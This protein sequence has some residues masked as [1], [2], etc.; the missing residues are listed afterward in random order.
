MVFEQYSMD[1]D[2]RDRLANEREHYLDKIKIMDSSD[3]DGGENNRISRRQ[4]HKGRG[5]GMKE[6]H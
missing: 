6:E 3:E 1:R 5:R 4:L 2:D